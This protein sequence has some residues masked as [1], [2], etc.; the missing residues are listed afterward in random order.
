MIGQARTQGFSALIAGHHPD[1]LASK[2]AVLRLGFSYTH[3]ELY[4]PAGLLEH[5]LPAPASSSDQKEGTLN[6]LPSS[7]PSDKTYRSRDLFERSASIASNRFHDH[8]ST[9]ARRH[10]TRA[11]AKITQHE[12]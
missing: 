2:R 7:M 6:S 4:P 12:N 9:S 10:V 1:N 8:E 11:A 5:S 3:D